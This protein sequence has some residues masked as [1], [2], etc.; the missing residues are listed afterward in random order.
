M[1][2]PRGNRRWV[3]TRTTESGTI[4]PLILLS[5]CR[6]PPRIRANNGELSRMRIRRS[7]A[8]TN[9]CEPSQTGL[10][11]PCK[12][13]VVSSILT[14]GSTKAQ[15]TGHVAIPTAIK[16]SSACQTKI[17]SLYRTV[18]RV[19]AARCG[20]CSSWHRTRYG[21]LLSIEAFDRN[22]VIHLGGLDLKDG[23]EPAEG[24][25]IAA[26]L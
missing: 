26:D 9:K 20:V 5:L 19:S 3:R 12:R 21:S 6:Q 17:R 24:P 14:G 15:F 1:E 2:H 18:P 11:S 22:L 8:C 13:K 10:Q 16:H 4:V 25:V 7:R 23:A